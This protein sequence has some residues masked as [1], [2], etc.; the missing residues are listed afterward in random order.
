MELKV[1]SYFEFAHFL[2]LEREFAHFL[3]LERVL[4]HIAQ[5]FQ[6]DSEIEFTCRN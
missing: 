4:G 6:I 2:D 1:P 5:L 3:D